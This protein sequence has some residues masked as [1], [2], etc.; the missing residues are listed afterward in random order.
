MA[1]LSLPS[2]LML[3]SEGWAVE[4]LSAVFSPCLLLLL[5]DSYKLYLKDCPP[6]WQNLYSAWPLVP[7]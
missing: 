5:P 1:P 4:A 6:N 7:G 2:F 3:R